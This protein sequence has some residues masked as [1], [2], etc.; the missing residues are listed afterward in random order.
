[1]WGEGPPHC[2]LRLRGVSRLS[3]PRHA[4]QE[5]ERLEVERVEMIR[6]H[7][8]QYTQLR[9]ETDMFNQSVS[10]LS[11]AKTSRTPVG[12]GGG[13]ASGRGEPS[14]PSKCL[15]PDGGG[16]QV[17]G[18]WDGLMDH[19]GHLRGSSHASAV[20]PRTERAVTVTR[21]ETLSPPLANFLPKNK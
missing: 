21:A 20:S 6:Q 1:M 14:S 15:C 13:G 7:L 17:H 10:R 3:L 16:W 2:G 5:L 11:R 9:H 8:C 18:P 19:P 4:G 12:R